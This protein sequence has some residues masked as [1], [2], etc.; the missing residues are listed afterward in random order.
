MMNA[1]RASEDEPMNLYVLY[2][3]ALK[4]IYTLQ[5][6][7]ADPCNV[8][9]VMAGVMFSKGA[10]EELAKYLWNLGLVETLSVMVREVSIKVEGDDIECNTCNF[11]GSR[12]GAEV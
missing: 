10:A 4:K 9:A 6:G 7:W 3:P 12:L 1:L 11:G 8:K 5:Y 2:S